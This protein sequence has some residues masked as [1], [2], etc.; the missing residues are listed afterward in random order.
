MEIHSTGVIVLLPLLLIFIVVHPI[1]SY[2]PL[3][4]GVFIQRNSLEKSSGPKIAILTAIISGSSSD[5]CE[6]FQHHS[7]ADIV[8]FGTLSK[9][10]YAK[11][12]GYDFIVATD[13]LTEAFN[14]LERRT[15]EAAWTKIAL[16]D[17][18]LSDYDWVFWS[19]AD[20]VILNFDVRLEDFLDPRYDIIACD[21]NYGDTAVG[22]MRPGQDIN[23]GQVFYKNSLRTRFVLHQAWLCHP[24]IT[25]GSYEQQWI[26]AVILKDGLEQY[27]KIYP[28]KAF[29]TLPD[30]FLPGDFIIHFWGYHGKELLEKFREIESR[31]GYMVER[32]IQNSLEE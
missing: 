8:A 9:D 18:F 11:R 15:L 25:P 21:K 12:H 28:Q 30:L 19:D 26:N 16:V 1:Y 14:V 13:R 22:T 10:L 5:R 32:E 20:S 29:N 6:R 27:V 24:N 4:G 3:G 2:E 7:Y 31:W 23:T 17:A